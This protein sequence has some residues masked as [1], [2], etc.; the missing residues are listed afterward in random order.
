[1][2][3]TQDKRD[4]KIGRAIVTFSWLIFAAK[5]LIVATIIAGV[6]IFFLEKP[7]WIAPIV[8]VILFIIY[9]LILRLIWRFIEW[10]D[11]Q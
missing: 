6:V 3:D 4:E 1:M 10:A 9:R 7:L 8:A 2:A 11:R 5:F